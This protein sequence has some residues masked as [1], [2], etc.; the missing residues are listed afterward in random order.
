MYIIN[1]CRP[2]EHWIQGYPPVV[3]TAECRLCREKVRL[4]PIE[5]LTNRACTE[6]R[7]LCVPLCR[8]LMAEAESSVPHDL[9][10]SSLFPSDETVSFSTLAM[11]EMEDQYDDRYEEKSDSDKAAD[12]DAKGSAACARLQMK[13]LMQKNAAMTSFRSKRISGSRYTYT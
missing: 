2:K 5:A 13:A 4:T 12:D 8:R 1:T 11:N 9:D 6:I 10:L 7:Q 3:P